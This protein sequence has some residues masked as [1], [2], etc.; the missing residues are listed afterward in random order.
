MTA[1]FTLLRSNEMIWQQFVHNY[2][3]G[4]APNA[5]DLL[6]WN[7]DGTRIP[8]KFQSFYLRNMYL[9]NNLVKNNITI[10]GTTIDITN[11]DIPVYLLATSEDYIVPW[12][13]CYSAVNIFKNTRF[14]LGGSG[15]VAGIVNHPSKGKYFYHTNDIA[16]ASADDWLKSS[17]KHSGSWWN[18]WLIWQRQYSGSSKKSVTIKDMKIKAIQAAPGSY[19]LDK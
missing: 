6:Y 14:I 1:A 10:A 15:H 19:V 5:F 9:E 17:T 8:A 16:E 13:S 18:D 4:K 11:I 12:D 2:L 3:L 7:A